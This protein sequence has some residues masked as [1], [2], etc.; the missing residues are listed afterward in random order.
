MKKT[1]Y[2]NTFTVEVLSE[3]PLS[4]GMSLSEIAEQGETGD[5]SIATSD[6]VVNQPIK[7]IKA[8]RALQAQGS[9]TEFFQ[10]DEKGNE[11]DY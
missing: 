2:R 4:T 6:K 5:L 8:A 1:I 9:S 10:M 11:I 7:G 3:Y